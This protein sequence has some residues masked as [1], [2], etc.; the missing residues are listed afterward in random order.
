MAINIPVGSSERI[1]ALDFLRG[2]ALLGILIMNIQLFAMP[3]GA[4]LNPT[5]YG[6]FNGLNK[7]V[8]M[9]THLFA[10]EKFMTIFSILF[11]AGIVLMTQR[12]IQRTG[13][14]IG[15]HYRRTFWLLLIG[16]GHAH[17]I[18]SGDILVTYAIAALV[19]FLFRNTRPTVLLVVGIL[20][21]AVHT[22]IYVFMGTTMEHWPADGLEMARQSWIPSQELM[23]E[24]IK[25]VTGTL[26]EQ[27]AF[28][29]AEATFLETFVLLML[30]FWRAAGL[31]LVGMALYKWG[32]LTAKRSRAFYFKGLVIG[33]L[34]GLGISGYGMYTNIEAGFSFEYSMYL[35]SQWNYWG[36]LFMSFG[37]I[38]GIML[39][40]KSNA[41]P[42]LRNRLAAVGQMA[43]TNYL[44]HSILCVL[45]FWGVGF[46]LIGTFDR[47][48]QLLVVIGIW[49]LQLLWS[50]PWLDRFHFGPFE[51]LWRSL[52]YLKK[53]PFKRELKP[54]I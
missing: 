5:A 21:V 13:K 17:L 18:W 33:C 26:N 30:L 29:S 6:D 37:Y 23:Q 38:S 36:S 15:L 25:A 1:Q 19:V 32:I 45:I 11:G 10:E 20:I 28:N 47:W 9:F 24:Q 27:I 44:M 42:W 3:M 2:F 22:L 8:W 43:L 46:G 4:Y 41:I 35:G 49:T 14:S 7:G 34:L 48:Q 39:L 53:Q 12:A 54:S 16:L 31:M 52:T 40:A 50:R 51:W